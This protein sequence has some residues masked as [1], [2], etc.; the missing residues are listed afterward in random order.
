MQGMKGILK[1]LCDVINTLISIETGYNITSFT[2][3]SVI[4]GRQRL[5][6]GRLTN[7]LSKP[8]AEESLLPENL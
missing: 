5:R 7:R 3:F 1:F 4:L 2:S 8:D 6:F